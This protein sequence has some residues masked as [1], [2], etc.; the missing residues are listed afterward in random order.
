MRKTRTR[1]CIW[2]S[3]GD[4]ATLT[5]WIADR[6]TPQKLV[7]RARIVSLSADRAGVMSI[8]R[9][10]GKS[11]VTI[12]RWQ[13]RY[14]ASG[15]AGLCRDK[16]RP[17]RKP[18]LPAE[19]IE[20]VLQTTLHEKP[21]AGTHWSIRKMA[22]ATGIS[23]T[24]IQKIW[25]A[26]GLKPHLV[27][28]FRL[29]NDKRFVENVQDVVGLYVNPPERAVVFSVDEKSQIQSPRTRGSTE[30]SQACR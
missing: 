23:Y 22:T 29:S 10:V 13:E 21:A 7:W 1:A 12:G 9:S 5:D 19:V 24:S 3:P 17:G 18:P 16:T 26:H 2:L 8:V 30:P 20:R 4:R 14:L 28:T 25:K 15:I 11:K 6:N 27:K